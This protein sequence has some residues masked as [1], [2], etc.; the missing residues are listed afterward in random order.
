MQPLMQ[1][2]ICVSQLMRRIPAE[3]R[4][5][6]AITLMMNAETL[7]FACDAARW[8]GP[9]DGTVEPV[10]TAGEIEQMQTA[11][12]TRIGTYL[13]GQDKAIWLL[14]P[15][16]A[17]TYLSWWEQADGPDPVRS[18]TAQQV[19]GNPASLFELMKSYLPHGWGMTTGL[20][21]ESS[22][23]RNTYNVL[24]R[25]IDPAIVAA[26]LR[27]MFGDEL[28]NPSYRLPLREPRERR[29]AHQF[30]FVHNKVLTEQAQ[31]AESSNVGDVEQAN[32]EDVQP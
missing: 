28:T 32:T 19:E 5:A 7:H 3:Q 17:G 6:I 27:S 8:L 22:F 31:P 10:L 9:G 4:G 12:G 11:L 30:M 13:T 20:P 26:T 21:V 15:K 14:E 18:Y 1:A 23:D 25:V 2:V 24:S 16:D 29:L